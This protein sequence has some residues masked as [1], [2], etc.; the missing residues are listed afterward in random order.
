MQAAAL[1]GDVHKKTAKKEA[2]SH[3]GKRF[4]VRAPGYVV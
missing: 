1:A 3:V 4:T 2:R